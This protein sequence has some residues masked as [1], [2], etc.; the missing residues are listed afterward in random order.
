MS[1][2]K[3]FI[4]AAGASAAGFSALPVLLLAGVSLTALAA[5]AAGINSAMKAGE[6]EGGAANALQD[7]ALN[8]ILNVVKKFGESGKAQCDHAGLVEKAKTILSEFSFLTQTQ[9]Y[10]VLIEK[11]NKISEE[12]ILSD[13]RS[14]YDDFLIYCDALM[15]QELKKSGYINELIS[16]KKQLSCLKFPEASG[17]VAEIDALADKKDITAD[18]IDELKKRIGEVLTGAIKKAN[19][20]EYGKLLKS[21]FDEIGYET[22]EDFETMLVCNRKIFLNKPAMKN[23]QV[24]IATN[25]ENSMVQMEVVRLVESERELNES[26]GSQS[27]RDA[28]VETE[29]CEDYTRILEKL[30]RNG[31]EVSCKM[32]KK[33]GEVAVKKVLM[34]YAGE[35]MGKRRS[36]PDLS[37]KTLRK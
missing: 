21:A 26:T 2:P 16:Y 3:V 7:R 36:K 28:E 5:A 17:L 19:N 31:V 15:R 12:K 6:G 32:R 8:D 20:L 35:C 14:R 9:Q 25:S 13:C 30:E 11:F 23:Y 24:Q 1:G 29:F 33:P 18:Q 22:D 4:L 34:P 37:A 10:G 27:V